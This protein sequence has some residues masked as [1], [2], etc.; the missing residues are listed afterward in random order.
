LTWE[1]DPITLYRH[2]DGYPDG[3]HGVIADIM[4]AKEIGQGIPYIVECGLL[5]RS[6]KAASLL[7]AADPGGTEPMADPTLHWDVDYIYVLTLKNQFGGSLADTNPEWVVEIRVPNER[8]ADD[9]TLD[10]TVIR[11]IS[12]V[13]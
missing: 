1:D 12:V 6:G 9:S 4:K 11:N 2:G 10:N 5:G 7:C 3:E 8:Y 13:G